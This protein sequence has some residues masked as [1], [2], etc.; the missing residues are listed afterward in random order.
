M[1]NKI[2]IFSN[3]KTNHF[4]GKLLP[5]YEL[6]FSNLEEIIHSIENITPN[7][8]IINKNEDKNIINFDILN[9]NYLLFYNSKI[10]N[11]PTKLE[12]VLKTPLSIKNL[13]SVI[14]NFVENLKIKFHDIT[15]VNEK[16]TNIK[17]NLHCYLTKAEVEI[18][19]YLI[20]EKI[21]N[22]NY[23]KENI[24]NIKTS[25]QTNSLESHLTRIRKKMNKIETSVK[26]HSKSEK[27][28]I[29]I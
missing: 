9:N 7:I 24:L 15:I 14:E 13:R 2:T 29:T 28:F 16:L 19:I 27:L 20:R 6:N 18:L 26:I 12:N 23:V 25:V 10:M 3:N 21:V 22:K 11:F 5:E 17:N 1:K 4:L 8:I